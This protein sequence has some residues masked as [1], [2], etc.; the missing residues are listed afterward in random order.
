MKQNDF[1]ILRGIAERYGILESMSMINEVSNDLRGP[2]FYGT[3]VTSDD[4]DKL[5]KTCSP[6]GIKVRYTKKGNP[7]ILFTTVDENLDIVVSNM[8]ETYNIK[9]ILT[10]K[11]KE[12]VKISNIKKSSIDGVCEYI[13]SYIDILS[14]KFNKSY[15]LSEFGKLTQFRYIASVGKYV[16]ANTKEV[17]DY[18]AF[19]PRLLEFY[20]KTSG[21]L[22]VDC[23]SKDNTVFC[24]FK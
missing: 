13:N 15:E 14:E 24:T 1:N 2:L 8:N 9:I 3:N 21:N 22:S 6:Y 18:N 5:R 19:Y 7:R 4:S 23:S 12:G 16:C 10:P 11:F 17:M 20:E